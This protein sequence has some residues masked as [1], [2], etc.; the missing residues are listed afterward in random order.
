M[1]TCT[2]LL[3]QGIRTLSDLAFFDCVFVG[4]P[5]ELPGPEPYVIFVDGQAQPFAQRLITACR[6]EAGFLGVVRDVTDIPADA[7]VFCEGPVWDRCVEILTQAGVRGDRARVL[8]YFDQDASGF[9]DFAM[10]CGEK[11]PD[12]FVNGV[13]ADNVDALAAFLEFWSGTRLAEG[14]L[15][16]SG[17]FYTRDFMPL[18]V[19][20]GAAITR[21]MAAMADDQSRAEYARIL[22]GSVEQVFT[23]FSKIVFG[24]QQYM[25]IVRIEPGDVVVNIGV[26]RGWEVPYFLTRLKGAGALHNMDPNI[27]FDSNPFAG[28][29]ERFKSMMTCHRIIVGDTNGKVTFGV[30]DANMIMSDMSVA[31]QHYDGEMI[32]FDSRSIDSLMNDGLADRLDYLKMDVEGGE[33]NILKGAVETIRRHRPKLAVAIYHEP[34]HFWDYPSFI[35]DTFEDYRFYLR[36]YGYSRFETL[37]YAVPAEAVAS[38]SG[39]ERL[40]GGGIQPPKS[41]VGRRPLV[42]AHLRD[43]RGAERD[44]YDGKKRILTRMFGVD[45]ATAELS[46]GPRVEADDV[47]GVVELAHST[48]VF[49]RHDYGD[50]RHAV[51]VGSSI[52]TI[53]INWVISQN[54]PGYVKCI[55]VRP[56]SFDAVY[57]LVHHPGEKFCDLYLFKAGAISGEWSFGLDLDPVSA[58]WEN[59]R[60]LIVC[61]G[62]RPG[63][64]FEVFATNDR[65]STGEKRILP[66]NAEKIE[67]VLTLKSFVN[68]ETIYEDAL[69]AR[70]GQGPL[71]IY[72]RSGQEYARVLEMKWD[73]R[74]VLGT[75]YCLKGD[76]DRALSPD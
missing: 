26:S 58:R 46:P 18:Q 29:F 17:R 30:K 65:H 23:K 63:E 25:D 69:G 12:V 19:E 11:L 44:I 51:T 53:D 36:Q 61:A 56:E 28:F 13:T 5:N 27:A 57:F 66:F 47:F 42:L 16:P 52:S 31:S 64:W 34:H 15:L 7:V 1:T 8:L 24:P 10:A 62:S 73:A 2:E 6:G 35:L 74:F 55:L 39:Q 32:E 54:V 72:R 75:T 41:S 45:W 59:G 49:T 67:G 50:G 22:F 4:Y 38:S 76:R 3:P 43:A 33:L 60:I 14:R 68:G 37:L 21:V 70:S 40:L 20:K 48:L 9:W 71:E